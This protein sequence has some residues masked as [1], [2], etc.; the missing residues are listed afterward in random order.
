MSKLFLIKQESEY[1][2]SI[3]LFPSIFLAIFMSGFY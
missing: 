3:S 1:I 2:C